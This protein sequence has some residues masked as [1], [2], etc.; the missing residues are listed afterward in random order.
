M[1]LG[2]TICSILYSRG[3]FTDADAALTA[4][5]L[6]AYSIGL[7]FVA[8]VRVVTQA[9]YANKDTKTPVWLAGS[10]LIIICV[11]CYF[12][13]FF[14]NLGF[15]GLA[16]AS[17]ISALVLFVLLTIKLRRHF[18]EIDIMN[19]V[20]YFIIILAISILSILLSSWVVEFVKVTYFDFGSSISFI[21]IVFL[22]VFAY[23]GLAKLAGLKELGMIFK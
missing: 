23:I 14:L 12:F 16:L 6:F 21:S 11:L 2:T 15:V 20:Q 17:S 18:H 5:A 1:F 19:I 10:N 13:G 7:V 9:F 22:S 8:G 4:K 3:E